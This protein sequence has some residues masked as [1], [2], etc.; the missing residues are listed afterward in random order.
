MQE[1]GAEGRKEASCGGEERETMRKK[2]ERKN[3]EMQKTSH[4]KMTFWICQ[5]KSGDEE[6]TLGNKI[7]FG[8][9]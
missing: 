8:A 4:H 9:S 5:Q 2:R 6:E 3:Q 1:E 7:G